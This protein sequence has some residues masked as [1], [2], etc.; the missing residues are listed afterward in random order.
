MTKLQIQAIQKIP[1]HFVIDGTDTCCYSPVG[2]EA[3][4]VAINPNL[5]PIYFSSKTKKWKKMQFAK[6]FNN[7]AGW[8]S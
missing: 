5:S 8:R 4:I 7:R 6:D 3:Y 2:T 1:K